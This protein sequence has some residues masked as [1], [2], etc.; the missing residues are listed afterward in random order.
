VTDGRVTH[1]HYVRR[2][3]LKELMDSTKKPSLHYQN[4]Q[5]GYR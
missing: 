1:R 4:P 3:A 5:N 2:G